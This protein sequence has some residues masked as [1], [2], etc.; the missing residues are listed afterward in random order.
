MI[1]R[2]FKYFLLL[3][4]SILVV[5]CSD[6]VDMPAEKLIP[7]S[8]GT[9][10]IRFRSSDRT[11]TTESD[12]SE[13]LIKNLLIAL[14]PDNV[15]E[16]TTLPVAVGRF[17]SVGDY[18]ETT[19]T[20]Q[21]TEDMVTGLFNN[22][23]GANCRMFALAN[24]PEE[25]ANSLPEKPTISQMRNVAVSSTFD[26]RMVQDCF[27][28]AGEGNISYTAGI[29]ANDPG[30]ASGKGELFRA[31][32]KIRL[33]I[34]LPESITI[35]NGDEKEVWIPENVGIQCI[36]SNGVKDAIA[37]PIPSALDAEPWKPALE[38]AYYDGSLSNAASI[39]TLTQTG[40]GEYP[41]IMDVPFYTYP[42]SWSESPEENHKTTITLMVAWGLQ[43]AAGTYPSTFHT[44][45][46]QVP[47]TSVELP[48]IDRN[49]SYNINLA[50]GMLGS[51]VPEKP[52]ELDPLSYQVVNWSS[53]QVD[54][55][56]QDFR[57]LVVNPNQV[58]VQNEAEI[59]IPFYSSHPV[60][61]SNISMTFQRFNFYTGTNGE[62]VNIEI[63]ESKLNNS[64]Y[65][66]EVTENGTTKTVTDTI[67]TFN[68]VKDPTTNQMS[69]VGKHPLEI[70][71]PVNNASQNITNYNTVDL[72]GNSAGS[73]QTVTNSINHFNRPA[74]PESPYSAYTFKVHIGHSDNDVYGEDIT[75]TQYPA[76][77][78]ESKRNPG[79]GNNNKGN[80]WVNGA[81][82]TDGNY[83]GVHGISSTASNKNPN[84]YVI[85]ISQLDA[86][87][88]FIIGDPRMDNINNNLQV[89]N[90]GSLTTQSTNAATWDNE[91]TSLY[92]EG[93]SRNRHLSFYYP[94]EEVAQTAIKGK[95]I[96]PKIRIASSYGVTSALSRNNARRRV[97]VY[98]EVDRPAGRWRLPTYSE[99]LYIIRLSSAGKIPMLF[100]H[101]P[102]GNRQASNC[103]YWTAQGL[104]RVNSDAT[105]T[106]I[107][108]GN[109]GFVK[110]IYDEW[111]WENSQYQITAG[112]NGNY[113]YT[114]GDVPRGKQ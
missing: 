52:L 24:L 76:M 43:G 38:D 77:Y 84:M 100:N 108:D 103:Y 93:N 12:N 105:L 80:V 83:G 9:I 30:K 111:Y 94:T 2:I 34:K 58:S 68:V 18:T 39:R 104:Y 11:R 75:I 19:A 6:S 48:H 32:A 61:L 67:C 74:T 113:T 69:L 3:T 112:T 91:A 14:Y 54:V 40:A 10:T 86:G 57:Y 42:N 72:T 89:N 33:N 79:G 62:V 92:Y 5:S 73:L 4:V 114:L 65:T 106:K 99:L 7:D 26:T 27:V 36:L 85:N 70:W 97:A 60:D 1:K 35:T 41:Y 44:Y 101:Y 90:N 82:G 28:M 96:A 66:H 59:S 98:Q 95:M 31:A 8:P 15:D 37:C 47:I 51:L 29:A 23:D 50:V 16:A 20:M 46:Y 107:G 13:T 49:Y 17:S 88:E 102:D 87:S 25:S 78:I 56:I 22:I 45:Y 63:P 109:D 71:T 81:N 110:G 55:N 53:E 64:T 21:L